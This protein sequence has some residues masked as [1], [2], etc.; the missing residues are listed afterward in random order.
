[1]VFFYSFAIPQKFQLI[2][3]DLKII[4]FIILFVQTFLQSCHAQFQ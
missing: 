3:F 1:M 4:S 2:I